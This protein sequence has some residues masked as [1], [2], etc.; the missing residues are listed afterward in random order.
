MHLSDSRIF[1]TLLEIVPEL[2]GDEESEVKTR[3]C[4]DSPI[5]YLKA[6]VAYQA[7]DDLAAISLAT[8]ATIFIID[9]R[10]VAT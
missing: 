7:V 9:F 3:L 8:T 5:S 10:G 1:R 6:L 2:N 4:T